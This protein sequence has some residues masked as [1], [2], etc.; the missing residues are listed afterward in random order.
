MEKKFISILALLTILLANTAPAW[1][2]FKKTSDKKML[3]TIRDASGVAI[4]KISDALQ[5]NNSPQE[6]DSRLC[7]LLASNCTPQENKKLFPEQMGEPLTL[8]Q[9]TQDELASLK[10][11]VKDDKD[12]RKN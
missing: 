4:Q 7:E 1:A 5:C 8:R 2:M 3:T 9:L 6:K 10:E 11:L 12:E